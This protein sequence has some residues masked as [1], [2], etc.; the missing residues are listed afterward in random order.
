LKIYHLATLPKTGFSHTYTYMYLYWVGKQ[1]MK[2]EI[3]LSAEVS[4]INLFKNR[5]GTISFSCPVCNSS[6][7]V[8]SL[9]TRS[10]VRRQESDPEIRLH[11]SCDAVSKL[12]V[13]LTHR[14]LNYRS[15]KV[16]NVRKWPRCLYVKHFHFMYLFNCIFPI[17]C[18]MEQ[19]YETF[20][21]NLFSFH[22]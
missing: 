15:L 4:Q 17:N 6:R 12:L 11:V 8:V 16:K 18:F 14:N 3:Q 21:P 5:S 7:S 20:S 10:W 19:F 2:F 13:P 9:S 22:G 1:G